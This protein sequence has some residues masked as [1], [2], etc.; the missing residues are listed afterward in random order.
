MREYTI[1][2]PTRD[3]EDYANSAVKAVLDSTNFNIILIDDFSN[4]TINYIQDKRIKL[5]KNSFKQSLSNLWNQGVLESA[6]NDIIIMSHK[7]R[8]EPKSFLKLDRLLDRKFALVAIRSFHFFGFNKFLFSITGLF[9]SAFT[10]GWFEDADIVCR[11]REHN[12]G[13]YTENDLDC[14]PGVNSH[15]SWKDYIENRDYFSRKWQ[16]CGTHLI[17]KIKEKNFNSKNLFKN[18][19]PIDYL[20]YNKSE[21][22]ML[23]GNELASLKSFEYSFNEKNN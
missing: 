13:C 22:Y 10:Q 18:V 12:L 19:S 8:P 17:K 23:G 20:P 16:I 14:V 7:A 5:L 21:N 1:V 2:I 15:S 11:L 6:T 3:N 4:K 9:D